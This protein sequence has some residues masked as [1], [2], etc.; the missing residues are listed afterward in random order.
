V[1]LLGFAPGARIGTSRPAGCLTQAS[2]ELYGS[3]RSGVSDPVPSIAVQASTWTQSDPRVLAVDAA[4]SVCMA[5]QGYRYSNPEQ[6]AD[7][8]W[9]STP[10]AIETATAVA[11]AACKQLVNLPNTWLAVE[12]AYQAALVGQ[13]LTTLANLQTSFQKMLQRAEELLSSAVLPTQNQRRSP[14]LHSPR[15]VSIVSAS[16]AVL[17]SRYRRTRAKRSVT[18]PG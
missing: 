5:R 15:T 18:P 12:A 4:W 1:A 6:A 2:D 16:A 13:N 8:H 11:D 3:G 17:S 10:S 9:P 14:P 7:A